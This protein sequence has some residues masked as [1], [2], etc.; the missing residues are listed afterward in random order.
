MFIIVEWKIKLLVFIF[1][2]FLSLNYK[3]IAC[4]PPIDGNKDAFALL[5]GNKS[6]LSES[7]KESKC[8]L[9]DALSSLSAYE[10]KVIANLIAKSYSLEA[11]TLNY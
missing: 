9:D 11:R 6:K 4:T 7:F 8:A 2:T 1:L 10:K 5:I 3:L